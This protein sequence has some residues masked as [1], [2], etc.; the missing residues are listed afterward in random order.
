MMKKNTM[1]CN[2]SYF[3]FHSNQINDKS[4]YID[5]LY[6]SIGEIMNN[7]IDFYL[8]KLSLIAKPVM[9]PLELSDFI[10]IYKEYQKKILLMEEQ[11]LRLYD[12][13]MQI[14]DHINNMVRELIDTPF[15]MLHIPENLLQKNNLYDQLTHIYSHELEAIS[16]D[17]PNFQFYENNSSLH[18]TNIQPIQIIENHDI[19]NIIAKSIENNIVKQKELD[20]FMKENFQSLEI[21][22]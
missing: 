2:G 4:L 6:I 20:I 13:S 9:I 22:C 18:I 15:D 17:F 21:P 5:G 12:V 10:K 16:K 7:V 1:Q 3:Y 14:K 8:D 11:L 19:I